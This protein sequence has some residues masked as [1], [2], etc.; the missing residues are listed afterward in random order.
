[1]TDERTATYEIA[2]LQAAAPDELPRD[3]GVDVFVHDDLDDGLVCVTVSGPDRDA[4]VDY[5]REQWGDDDREWFA[6]HVAGGVTEHLPVRLLVDR[7]R[8]EH[9]VRRPPPRRAGRVM[10]AR[11]IVESVRAFEGERVDD[12]YDFIGAGA[13]NGWHAVA[14]WGRDGWDLGS[15]PYVVVLFRGDLERA[16]YVEG[17]ITVETFATREDRE[18]ATD[19]TALFYWRADDADWLDRGDDLKGS[20]SWKRAER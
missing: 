10:S 15:W 19:E 6:E 12:G 14:G 11:E 8:D 3:R 7:R 5:V 4:L 16:I 17:D 13:S 18:T 1:M 2:R 9:A 20:F